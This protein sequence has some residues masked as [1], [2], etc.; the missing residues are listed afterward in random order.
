MKRPSQEEIDN[1]K[2]KIEVMTRVEMAY[3]RR[4]APSGHPIFRDDLPLYKL[5]EARFAELGGISPEIS[6]EIGWDPTAKEETLE[7]KFSAIEGHNVALVIRNDKF[8]VWE[9]EGNMSSNIGDSKPTIE[10]AINSAIYAQRRGKLREE[11][12]AKQGDKS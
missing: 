8:Q 5:F 9:F 11:N 7:E 1:W 2:N 6:K 4:F 12:R 10:E 3:F